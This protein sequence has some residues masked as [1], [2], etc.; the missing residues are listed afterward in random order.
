M[1]RLRQRAVAVRSGTCTLRKPQR[2]DTFG[3]Q[4]TRVCVF[5][6]TGTSRMKLPQPLRAYAPRRTHARRRF[7]MAVAGHGPL[8]HP[9]RYLIVC[10]ICSP[11]QA[12][13]TPSRGPQARWAA[14]TRACQSLLVLALTVEAARGFLFAPAAGGDLWRAA[15]QG[16]SHRTGRIAT[17]VRAVDC[18]VDVWSL[19]VSRLLLCVPNRIG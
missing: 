8:P 6:T 10:T 18:Y 1:V 5:W 12:S 14:P 15:G 2:T 9:L 13:M 17:S 19:S 7:R 3:L 11:A 16:S 4:R